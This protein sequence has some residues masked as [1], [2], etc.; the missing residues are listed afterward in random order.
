MRKIVVALGYVCAVV[1]LMYG[2]WQVGTLQHVEA[3]SSAYI[4]SVSASSCGTPPVATSVPSAAFC[5][6]TTGAYESLNGGSWTA[7]GGSTSAGVTSWNGL[8]GAVTYSPPT[9]PVVSVNG[10]TGAVT[11]AATTTLQ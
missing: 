11:I 5:F 2:S 1:A 8:T 10:K 4:F 3:Q 7:L 9:A 6:I